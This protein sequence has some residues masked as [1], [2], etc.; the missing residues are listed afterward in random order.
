MTIEELSL[1]VEGLLGRLREDNP[2]P[3]EKELLLV[4]IDAIR[5]ISSTGHSYDFEDYRKSLSAH[6]PPPVVAVFKTREE[7]D[8]WLHA[9]PKPPHLTYVLIG[10][11][12]YMVVYLRDP[13]RRS[14]GP[15]PALAYHLQEM[16]EAGLPPAVAT[17]NTRAEADAWFGQ[18]ADPPAQ[19]VIQIGNEPYLAVHHR[20]VHHRAIYPFSL[21]R[22]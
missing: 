21:A 9:H 18:Q 14:L 19:S 8:A 11:A 5:F 12:Y 20:N 4:A 22:L 10:D 1:E 3:K 15:H 2:S 6:E 13:D 7:A 17:F 16:L